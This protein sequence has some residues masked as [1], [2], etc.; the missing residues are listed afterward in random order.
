[1]LFRSDG[2]HSRMLIFPSDNLAIYAVTNVEGGRLPEI[3]GNDI[4][5]QLL[6]LSQTDWAAAFATPSASPPSMAS[7]E[8]KQESNRLA[9]D[10]A[11]PA[12]GCLH[13]T[14]DGRGSWVIYRGMRARLMRSEAI[15]LAKP[16]QFNAQLLE[17]VTISRSGNDR[18]TVK[19]DPSS[20]GIVFSRQ[21]RCK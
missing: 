7:A 21:P 5:D 2:F 15:W 4:A 19:M 12:Y 17:G 18:L 20:E 6:G 9:G 13:I 3:V 16:E 10:Y 8:S 14:R 11:H 1:M